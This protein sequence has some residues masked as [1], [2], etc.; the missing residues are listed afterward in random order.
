MNFT[1]KA[2]SNIRRMDMTNYERIEELNRN[3]YGMDF[4]SYGERKD[5]E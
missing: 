3:C 5:E 4:C 1:A 2:L